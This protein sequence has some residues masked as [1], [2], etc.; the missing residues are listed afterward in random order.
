[1]QMTESSVREY[2][3]RHNELVEQRHKEK[4]QRWAL[5]LREMDWSPEQLTRYQA[6]VD[7]VGARLDAVLSRN[8]KWF[9]RLPR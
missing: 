1:M 8:P 2:V 5:A 9:K 4:E 7:A 6:V 3:R